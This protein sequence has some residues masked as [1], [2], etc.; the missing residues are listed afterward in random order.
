MR[1]NGNSLGFNLILLPSPMV[2]KSGLVEISIM[3]KFLGQ[4][5]A[6]EKQMSSYGRPTSCLQDFITSCKLRP[7]SPLMFLLQQN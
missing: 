3:V 4:H 7:S 2:D 5:H 1:E 6:W